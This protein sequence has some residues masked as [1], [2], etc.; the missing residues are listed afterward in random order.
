M[1]KP[2]L[3]LACLSAMRQARAAFFR[4]VEA[5]AASTA[6]LDGPADL[7]R[8]HRKLLR[9]EG[10]AQIAEFFYVLKY[11]GLRIPEDLRGFL[12]RHN[13]DMQRLIETCRNG[14]TEGGLSLQRLKRAIFSSS[15]IEYVL[16]ES[17]GGKARLDQM[18]LQRIFTQ[19]MSFETCRTLL[20]VLAE[21][22]LLQR[23]E[24]NQVIIGSNGVLEDLYKAHLDEITAGVLAHAS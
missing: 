1:S 6:G 21:Y 3:D 2:G 16:H 15:Q 19:S 20:V 17:S 7:D 4:A 9:T 10:V 22:G 14:Y 5:R 11:G 8:E 24:F 23:W 18:S 12:E 13:A